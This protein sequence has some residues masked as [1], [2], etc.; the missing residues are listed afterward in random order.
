M[1]GER[2][3]ESTGRVKVRRCN[4]CEVHFGHLCLV[5]L[6][7]RR[8]QEQM[9]QWWNSGWREKDAVCWDEGMVKE[10]GCGGREA[11]GEGECVVE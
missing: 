10:G 9:T 8:K 11:G 2:G 3:G 1:K 4:E 6:L 5:Y 7:P